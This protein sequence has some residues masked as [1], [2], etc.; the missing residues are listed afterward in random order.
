MQ[1]KRKY[2]WGESI[3]TCAGHRQ[4][5][6]PAHRQDQKR[7]VP[8][9]DG[10]TE[11]SIPPPAE[12]EDE[13]VLAAGRHDPS[14]ESKQ[15]GKDLRSPGDET[16]DGHQE[17]RGSVEGRRALCKPANGQA[18]LAQC[19]HDP[20]EIPRGQVGGVVGEGHIHRAPIE[21]L[22]RHL[23]PKS[24]AAASERRGLGTDADSVLRQPQIDP[25]TDELRV[26]NVRSEGQH[27]EGPVYAPAVTDG[28]A[29]GRPA[30]KPSPRVK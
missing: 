28:T 25:G 20:P 18:V 30:A 16:T 24:S 22:Q 1:V 13:K 14:K 10:H 5:T 23:L 11:G 15:V 26:R 19:L 3:V 17:G 29:P 8:A 4:A 21:V 12:H 2:F 27:R 7:E 9:G 6:A